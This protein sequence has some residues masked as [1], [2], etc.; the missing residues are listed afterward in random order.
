MGW[1]GVPEDRGGPERALGLLLSNEGVAVKKPAGYSIV[2]IDPGGATGLAWAVVGRSELKKLGATQALAAAKADGRLIGEQVQGS[3]EF[4][5]AAYCLAWIEVWQREAARR[6]RGKVQVHSRIVMED[7]I[8][9]ERTKDRSLLAPVRMI[10]MLEFGLY[11]F[12]SPT[13]SPA[14]VSPEM[15]KLGTV[16]VTKQQPSD[17]K[18]VATDERLKRWGLWHAGSPHVRDAIR[19]MIIYLRRNEQAMID[20]TYGR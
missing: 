17:A 14:Q 12:G 13:A 15:A 1:L 6:T 11:A 19:H 7:F 5:S 16:G 3:S 9:R 10:A 2:S 4:D 8:L 20:G 18:S